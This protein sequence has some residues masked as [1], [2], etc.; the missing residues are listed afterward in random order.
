MKITTD[1]DLANFNFW[2]GAKD[3]SFD[4]SELKEIENIL[5]DLYPD[6]MTETQVNDIFWFDDETLCEWIG[7]DY[8]E[9][10]ERE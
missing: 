4:Y 2:S 10:L 6:G 3:H 9:Y 8:D 1:L 7:I 5:E